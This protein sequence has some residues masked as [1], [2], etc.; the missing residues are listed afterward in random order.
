V[1]INKRMMIGATF[2][3][4]NPA[5]VVEGMKNTNQKESSKKLLSCYNN[6]ALEFLK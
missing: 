3:Y 2:L 5:A 1:Q 4:G 6:Y